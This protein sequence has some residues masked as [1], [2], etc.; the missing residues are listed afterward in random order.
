MLSKFFNTEPVDTF[1]KE[2]A[3]EL[4][5]TLPPELVS[6]SN[7]PAERARQQ[8]SSLLKKQLKSFAST[9]R[10]NVYQKA[11]VGTRLEHYLQS[12]GYPAE[13]CKAFDYDVVKSLTVAM[14]IK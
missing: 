14:T 3:G 8:M 1:A 11:V 5:R 10:L 6:A 4:M 7:K 9:T 12:V 13:F 2:I